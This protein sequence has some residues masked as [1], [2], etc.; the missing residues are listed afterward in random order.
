MKPS[1]VDVFTEAYIEA[2]LWSSTDDEGNPLD[3]N[4]TVD[5]IAPETLERMRADCA[6]FLAECEGIIDSCEPSYTG[7]SKWAYAGHDFWLTRVGS[8]VG[9]GDGDWPEPEANKLTEVSKRFG[10]VDLCIGDD[11]LIYGYGY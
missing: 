1:N 7:C 2:A 3:S 11:G 4:Y 9:F 6:A 5:S 10:N 8:G